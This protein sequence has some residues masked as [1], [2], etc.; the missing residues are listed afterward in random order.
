[1]KVRITCTVEL[2]DEAVKAIRRHK[3]RRPNSY[4]GYPVRDYIK[5]FVLNLGVDKLAEIIFKEEENAPLLI[6]G[7][8]IARLN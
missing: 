3:N 8:D 5:D 6:K 4:V 1:M 2:N 7:A